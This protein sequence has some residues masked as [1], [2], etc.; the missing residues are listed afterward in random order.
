MGNKQI[1][2]LT[3][4]VAFLIMASQVIDVN[5]QSNRTVTN[6]TR[7]TSSRDEATEALANAIGG[8][9]KKKN[10]D[11]D[12]EDSKKEKKEKKKKKNDKNVENEQIAEEQ[13]NQEPTPLAEDEVALIVSGDGFTKEE[14]T[15][16]A[17]RSAIELAFGTFV[18]SN[19]KILNDEIVKDE[20]ITVSSGNVRNYK[21]ISEREE[22]GKYY[23]TMQT[24]VSVGKLIEYTKS[25]GA[26]AELAGATFAMNMKIKKMQEDN[27]LRTL[28]MLKEQVKPLLN[29]C[30]SFEDIKVGEPKEVERRI[31]K[32]DFELLYN[33]GSYTKWDERLGIKSV[34]VPLRIYVKPNNNLIQARNIVNNTA[35]ALAE[36]CT[37]DDF[38][39]ISPS[40]P[41]NY[42]CNGGYSGR[43]YYP[44]IKTAPKSTAE[45]PNNVEVS[46][47]VIK[48]AYI[49]DLVKNYI[50]MYIPLKNLFNFKIIDNLGEYT[51]CSL[52]FTKEGSFS[53]L[54]TASKKR[55]DYI[56]D[57]DI[58]DT[59]E[60]YRSSEKQS[61]QDD[62]LRFEQY[63]SAPEK[64]PSYR[65]R[66]HYRDYYIP[67][68]Y[69]MT[70]VDKNHKAIYP[71]DCPY[72][73]D[74][75][76]DKY[77]WTYQCRVMEG[78]RD[79]V[80]YVIDVDLWYTLDDISKISEIKVITTN[81]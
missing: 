38:R 4:L 61:I 60:I 45:V 10:K 5:A 18:S 21:Y 34:L 29:N 40:T 31:F 35:K 44:N 33:G 71:V 3:L 58:Y 23:V 46:D 24:T 13:Q 2:R 1:R 64:D 62:L 76:D 43:S 28:N 19:T 22:N 27:I 80:A 55:L 70:G 26:S 54:N 81:E 30:Y 63:K 53:D 52:K 69:L 15:K 49:E 47:D 50:E 59:E 78:Y 39:N 12:K 48:E 65:G 75:N 14:A 6:Q 41:R 25:K 67:K 51:Y 7:T 73:S 74:S 9:F 56:S 66:F 42:D 68:G 57:V 16:A 11:K 32:E 77:T 20:V 8:L 36:H 37:R 79:V 17:L 72:F